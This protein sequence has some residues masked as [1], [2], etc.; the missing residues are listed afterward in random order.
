M[1]A[2]DAA[3]GVGKAR[4]AQVVGRLDGLAS[5]GVLDR[6]L[7]RGGGLRALFRRRRR[8]RRRRRR[9]RW[10]CLL[11]VPPAQEAAEGV[12]QAGLVEVV[13]RVVRVVGSLCDLD[14]P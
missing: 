7:R 5:G 4:L 14:P 6:L 12:G 10:R 11:R 9:R 3:D 2:E 1:P 8:W 13:S